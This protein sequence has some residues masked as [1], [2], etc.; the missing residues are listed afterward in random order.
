MWKTEGF[1]GDGETESGKEEEEAINLTGGG[2]RRGIETADPSRKE[3]EGRGGGEILR[4]S[5][6]GSRLRLG[7][8]WRRRFLR[9]GRKGAEDE[10]RVGEEGEGADGEVGRG[11]RWEQREGRVDPG[12]VADGQAG[13]GAAT[14][15]GAPHDLL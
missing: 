1:D 15:A 13:V 10:G 8:R 5:V 2:D 11:S 6:R 4:R 12:A 3:G 7:L 14:G 9:R